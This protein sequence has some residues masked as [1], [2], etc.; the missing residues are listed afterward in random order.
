MNKERMRILKMIEDGTVNAEEGA[1][2]LEAVDENNKKNSDAASSK[3]GIKHFLGDAVDKIKNVDFDL[4]FGES[5]SFDYEKTL[6]L[7]DFNDLDISIA[8]GSLKLE[9]WDE[10]HVK[11][12]YHVKV[13]QVKSEEEARERFLTDGEF[14]IKSGLLRLASPSKKMKTSVTLNIPKKRYEF[15]KAKLTNGGIRLNQVD[16]DHFQLKTSNGKVQLAQVSGETCKIETG[17]G[18]ITLAEGDLETCEVDTINGAVNL[19]GL[20]GKSDVSALSG[21]IT[22]E[23]KGEKAHTGFYKTTAGSVKVSLPHER[24]IDGVLRS[25]MGSL[26][27][28]LENYKI[29]KDKKDVANKLL[30]FEAFE[31]HEQAFHIEA[32]TKTGSVTVKTRE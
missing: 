26:N 5:V 28:H 7:S 31:E 17:N 20:Y 12:S 15:I 10:P 8:N 22:V 13:Y 4:S 9:T 11:A 24:R 6:E 1:K 30:E 29:L 2:L 21:S 23:H 16:S 25:K 27:C 18:A 3:Y 14:S 19:S 32:E